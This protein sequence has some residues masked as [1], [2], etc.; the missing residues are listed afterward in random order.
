MKKWFALLLTILLVMVAVSA[1]AQTVTCTTR[2]K[3]PL[4]SLTLPDSFTSV[5]A[6]RSEDPDLRLHYTGES[7]DLCVY[8][9]FSGNSSIGF[10]VNSGSSSV[11]YGGQKM[12]CEYTTDNGHPCVIYSWSSSEQAI[13]IYFSWY[14]DDTA[15]QEV[16]DSIMSSIS[17]D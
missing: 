1:S 5:S 15:A 10:Q 4:F 8:V 2:D 6:S 14:G 16:I 3:S 17:F 12:N 9:S 11:K 7:V 13:N